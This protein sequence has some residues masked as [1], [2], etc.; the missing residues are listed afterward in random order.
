MKYFIDTEFNGMG[1]SLISL[2]LVPL[3]KVH[4]ELYVVI[5]GYRNEPLQTWVR[6]NVIPILDTPGATP[7]Y[8]ARDRLPNAIEEYL[9]IAQRFGP[10]HLVSDWPDDLKYFMEGLITGPG[11]M[12]ETP[13]VIDFSIFR[14]DAYPTSLE[15]AVQHNALWDARALRIKYLA[16]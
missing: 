16:L 11:E 6:D 5:E 7:Q 1:G 4:P 10:I 3:N 15:Q 12:I 8:I 2:A 13:S 14:I 9:Q